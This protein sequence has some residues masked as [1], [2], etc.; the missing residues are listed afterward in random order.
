MLDTRNIRSARQRQI[1]SLLNIENM[2]WENSKRFFSK[3][4]RFSKTMVLGKQHVIVILYSQKGDKF[5]V[6]KFLYSHLFAQDNKTE[7]IAHDADTRHS[8]SHNP[9]DPE[10]HVLDR[11]K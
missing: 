5:K 7:D 2:T 11:N 6:K 9:G 8:H 10:A 4:E 3:F 1:R